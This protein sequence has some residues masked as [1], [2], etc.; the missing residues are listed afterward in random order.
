MWDRVVW[1]ASTGVIHCVFYQS[2]NLQNF[3]TFPNKNLGREGASDTFRQVPLQV[4]F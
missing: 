3:F 4:N 2:P 1:R